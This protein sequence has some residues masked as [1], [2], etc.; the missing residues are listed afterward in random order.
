[1]VPARSGVWLGRV[2]VLAG[3]LLIAACA[4]R[5]PYGRREG[6]GAPAPEP[7][8]MSDQELKIRLMLS[9]DFNDDGIVTRAELEAGLKLQFGAADANGDGRLDPPEVRTENDHRF[10]YNGVSVPPL[11]DWDGDGFISFDEF[12][13][14][15]RA[16]FALLDRDYNGKLTP[17]ELRLPQNGAAAPANGGRGQNGRGGRGQGRGRGD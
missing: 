1:M 12:A 16:A 5:G 14:T 7:P 15:A 6:A 17:D 3:L 10:T 4:G 11:T 13:T 2:A 8:A 9:Y